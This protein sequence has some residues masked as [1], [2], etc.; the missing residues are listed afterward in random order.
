M[1]PLS[2]L[3][4]LLPDPE[5]VGPRWS[6]TVRVLSGDGDE[7]LFWRC[8]ISTWQ[9]RGAKGWTRTWAGRRL[10]LQRTRPDPQPFRISMPMFFVLRPPF[11][12]SSPTARRWDAR[13]SLDRPGP[14]VHPVAN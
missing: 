10:Q 3:S 9:G 2:A 1:A 11:G 4:R 12:R 7:S 6:T 14:T 5:F 8:P 13:H